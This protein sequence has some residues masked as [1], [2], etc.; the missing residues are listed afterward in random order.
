MDRNNASRCPDCEDRGEFLPY[1]GNNNEVWGGFCKGCKK[2]YK[3]VDEELNRNPTNDIPIL[4]C[5]PVSEHANEVKWEEIGDEDALKAG[6]HVVWWRAAG[7]WHHGI[8]ESV[9]ST[10]HTINVYEVGCCAIEENEHSAEDTWAICFHSPMYRVN[11]PVQ[12]EEENPP[13]LVLM[14]ARC[15]VEP[16]CYQFCRDNC[17]HYAQFC[18]TGNMQSNQIKQ[19]ILNCCTGW[20]KKL[21]FTLLR[22]I[23][24]VSVAEIVEESKEETTKSAYSNQNRKDWIGVVVLIAI[25]VLYLIVCGLLIYCNDV[26]RSK[27]LGYDISPFCSRQI[28]C[29]FLKIVL[30]SALAV[31]LSIVFSIP[32]RDHVLRKIDPKKM[33]KSKHVLGVE[34]GLGIL[35]ALLGNLVGYII[36]Q[37][38]PMFC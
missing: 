16:K 7:Y 23:I 13:E 11:Y 35:G 19:L 30:Q 18:K 32:I 38:L 24:E 12:V 1:I 17:E 10:S 25:E 15:R 37:I 2:E 26:K 3:L 28:V 27:N 6:D 22:V 4:C 8:V 34:I 31:G 36:F 20:F 21:I 14:R 5:L 33:W 9:N 29:N